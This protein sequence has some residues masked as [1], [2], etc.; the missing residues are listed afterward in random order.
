MMI[1]ERKQA[2]RWSAANRVPQPIRLVD[3]AI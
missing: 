3:S 1:W 2:N